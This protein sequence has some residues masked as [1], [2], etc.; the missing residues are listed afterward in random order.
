MAVLDAM[1]TIQIIAIF[2]STVTV[3]LAIYAIILTS[4]LIKEAR[5]YILASQITPIKLGTK[6]EPPSIP[7]T[8]RSEQQKVIEAPVKPIQPEQQVATPPP[9]TGEAQ[10]VLEAPRLDKIEDILIVFGLEG[11]VIFDSLGQVI[12]YAGRVEP[13][14]V[15]AIMTELYNVVLMSGESASGI[16][17]W[18]GSQIIIT[19]IGKIDTKTIYLYAK[20]PLETTKEDINRLTETCKYLLESM[21]RK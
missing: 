17:I 9:P 13:G 14:K 16:T 10:P 4:R 7:E 2:A 1:Q 8:E 11:I 5:T 15:A 20:A 19:S 12:E 18:D 6:R 21:T 3:I